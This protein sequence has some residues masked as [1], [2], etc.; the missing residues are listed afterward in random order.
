MP[1]KKKLYNSLSKTIS[2]SSVSESCD[3]SGVNAVFE[4]SDALACERSKFKIGY[5]PDK[6]LATAIFEIN[7][8]LSMLL[9]R[10]L[11]TVIFEDLIIRNI[12]L[13]N[14]L[15]AGFFCCFLL[16]LM[17]LFLNTNDIKE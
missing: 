7:G 15:I 4:S 9:M 1:E 10:N 5:E 6:I 11:F 13:V 14:G 8:S 17:L 16:L 12:D 3:G 2:M